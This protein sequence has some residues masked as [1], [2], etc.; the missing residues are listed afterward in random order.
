V[1]TQQHDDSPL[2]QEKIGELQAEVQKIKARKAKINLFNKGDHKRLRLSRKNL[3]T[4]IP[5]TMVTLGEKFVPDLNKDGTSNKSF[6]K[7]PPITA[8]L[9]LRG[10][11]AVTIAKHNVAYAAFLVD[12][13]EQRLQCSCTG[14]LFL[15]DLLHWNERFDIFLKTGAN[16]QARGLKCSQGD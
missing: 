9:F 8:L 6:V 1:E 3:C 15:A 7:M 11:G 13:L 5:H 2:T 14:T 16:H 12:L 10:L 4:F